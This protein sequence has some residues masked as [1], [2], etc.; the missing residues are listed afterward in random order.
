M[1]ELKVEIEKLGT[2]YIVTVNQFGS[3]EREITDDFDDLVE[4][5]KVL[6]KEVK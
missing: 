2:Y 4:Y 3:S 6:F 5:L 1:V